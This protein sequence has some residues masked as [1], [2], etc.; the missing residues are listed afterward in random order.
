MTKTLLFARPAFIDFFR[1]VAGQLE[2]KVVSEPFEFRHADNSGLVALFYRAFKSGHASSLTE[3]EV[4]DVIQRDRV[5]RVLPKTKA[6]AM[7]HAMDTAIASLLASA[8]CELILSV[9]VDN[10][11]RHL[12]RRQT[13]SLGIPHVAFGGFFLNGYARTYHRQEHEPW[14]QPSQ[15]EIQAALDKLI[16]PEYQVTPAVPLSLRGLYSPARHIKRHFIYR[17]KQGVYRY[18]ALKDR[19]PLNW[20]YLSIKVAR[21]R[22]KFFDFRCT[23][24]FADSFVLQEKK[25]KPLIHMPLHV[26]PEG[27]IDYWVKNPYF[28][29]YENQCIELLSLLSKDYDCI[30]KEHPGMLG[31]RHLDFYR[32]LT[33]IPG[34]TLAPMHMLSNDLL[35]RADAVVSWSSSVG[36]EAAL[37]GKVVALVE[38]PYYMDE[39]DCW[40]SME[41]QNSTESLSQAIATKLQTYDSASLDQEA[42]MAHVLS[43]S[44]P[45]K[46]D[47]EGF[48]ADDNIH[49]FVRGI[50]P[51]VEQKLN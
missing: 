50:R 20:E 6:A 31:C 45:A 19:D 17:A 41:S 24:Y 49:Q 13:A 8:D 48:K 34:V 22:K 26:I 23:Q 42:L 16:R 29:D 38:Q 35:T 14:R 27:T 1:K 32:R 40:I 11:I 46:F 39:Q 5:L 18:Q 25:Q 4:A 15:N 47:A 7:V 30:V 43:T 9:P 36:L 44:I 10:Y 12:F 37:R 3:A 33:N 21:D 2:L 51:H 28:L